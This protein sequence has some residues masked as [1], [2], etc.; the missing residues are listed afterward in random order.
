MGGWAH[1]RSRGGF[2]G[3]VCWPLLA[4]LAVASTGAPAADLTSLPLGVG[5]GTAASLNFLNAH[6]RATDYMAARAT[7]LGQLAQVAAAQRF[8]MLGVD[9]FPQ[10]ASLIGEAGAVGATLVGFNLEGP[11]TKDDLVSQERQVG[12]LVKAAGLTYVFGPTETA[13]EEYFADLAPWADVIVLQSQRFQTSPDYAATVATL[14]GKIRAA[15][16]AVKVWAQVSVN[17]PGNRALT[18]A[19]T[20]ANIGQIAAVVDGV[21]IFY[22]PGDPDRWAI[23]MQVIESLRPA[24]AIRRHL[25]RASFQPRRPESAGGLEA[26]QPGVFTKVPPAAA[27]PPSPRPLTDNPA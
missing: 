11:L 20:L 2:P 21:H 25:L 16:P 14:V 9:D 4:A 15:N 17:P 13:L 26:G 10:A 27:S 19:E 3:T 6:L 8:L 23:A 12:Q 24:P 7:D 18:A 1:R 22:S 5:L